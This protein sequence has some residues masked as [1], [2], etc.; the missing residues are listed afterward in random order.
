MM[1]GSSRPPVDGAEQAPPPL[2]PDVVQGEC[3]MEFVRASG[4]GG[5]HRN[6]R[7]TGVRLTHLPTGLVVMATERRSQVQN[8]ALALERMVA[9]LTARRRKRRPRK[10][11]K[12]SRGVRQRELA[13]KARASERKAARRAPGADE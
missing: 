9:K 1:V 2:D 8:R 6:R 13:S 10:P 5:Q 12:K 4:P 11:T 7:E 3:D